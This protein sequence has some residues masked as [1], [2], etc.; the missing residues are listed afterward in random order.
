MKVC[1]IRT[2]RAFLDSSTEVMALGK[3]GTYS[4]GMN[5]A[6]T[7]QASPDSVNGSEANIAAVLIA[8]GL[9]TEH[10]RMRE[11]GDVYLGSGCAAELREAMVRLSR[12]C[13]SS[14]AERD[15]GGDYI[16]M[17]HLA[18][19][20]ME[21]WGLPAIGV[22][23]EFAKLVLV[24]GDLHAPTRDT[25][26]LAA[27]HGDAVDAEEDV[28][29]GLFR[30]AIATARHRSTEE[31][32]YTE[33]RTFFVRRPVALR[34][35]VSRFAI[36][37]PLLSKV[38]SEIYRP[39]PAGAFVDGVCRLCS[40]CGSILWPWPDKAAYP[41][42]RCR[43]RECRE[44]NGASVASGIIEQGEQPMLLHDAILL[45][46][47]GPGLGEIA[48]HDA[49]V[50]S[51]RDAMMYP[52]CDAADVG[53]DGTSVGIDVKSYSSPE[54]LGRYFQAKGIG[55][56]A[57]FRERII[58][59]PDAKI[60]NAPEYMARLVRHLDPAWEIKIMSVSDT[61]REFRA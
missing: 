16:L 60:R 18:T 52:E 10:R 15:L 23:H 31:R 21:E 44:E 17:S 50:A 14:G 55:G 1:R 34:H 24:D 53:L 43:L 5:D 26:L 19:R 2:T 29:H 57:R 3:L 46:W 8:K 42:G 6:A 32:L 58:A 11:T 35:D 25:M 36:E 48:I 27:E 54:S 28:Y 22:E 47:V 59:I 9:L 45:Y 56:L 41:N 40:G 51:G 38:V 39:V 20:P 61:I 30:S 49:L 37:H 7:F 33:G 4:I 12:L 13:L